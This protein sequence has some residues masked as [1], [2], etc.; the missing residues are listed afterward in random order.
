MKT[1][2]S[3]RS[4][5]SSWFC[6]LSASLPAA[7]LIALAGIAGA[8][9]VTNYFPDGQFESPNGGQGPWLN[10]FG[11]DTLTF[12][13]TGGNP[14]GCLQISDAGSF[15]GIA[16]VNPATGVTTTQPTLASMGLVAGQ[17]YTFVMDMQ[18]VSGSSIGGIKIESWTDTASIGNSGNMYPLSPTANWKTYTFIYKI[19]AGSTHLNIVPIWGPNSTVNY[20]NIGVVVPVAG[21]AS[22]A[23]TSPTNSQ[24]VYSNFT[25]AVTTAANPGAVT[26]VQFYVDNLLVGNST[27]SP[28]SF[29]AS[30]ISSGSH[31][32]KAVALDTIGNRATSSPVSISVT[33]AAIPPFGAYESFNYGNGNTIDSTVAVTG[34]GFAGNWSCGAAGTIVPGLVYPN[35]AVAN[36][37]M[38]SS[39]SYQLES[40][41]TVPSGAG[42]VWASFIFQQSGDNGGNR[43]GF[44]LEDNA[45]N[46]VM[47]AYQQN[48]AAIGNPAL[49]KV[50]GFTGNSGQL[51]PY[52]ATARNYT[53]ANFYVLKL[54]YSGGSLSSVS[55]YSN[56]TAGQGTA[57]TPDFT[58][59]SGLS[60]IGTLSVIGIVHQAAM[61]ITLDEVRLGNTFADVVGA[62]LTPTI[63][64]TVALSIAAGNQV[65]WNAFATNYYQPQSST[66]GANWNNLGNLL[67]GSAVTSVYDSAP[68]AFYQVQE[69]LPVVAEETRNGGFEQGDG[70]GG[71][72]YW[73]GGG[74]EPATQST[75]DFHSGSA[76]ESLF[77]TNST[78]AAQ[79]SDLQQNLLNMTGSGITGGSTYYF[80]FWA[81]SLGR[82]PAGGSV[83]Q[84]KISW[85]NSSAAVVGAVGFNAFT[86]GNGTWS[87]ISTGALVAPTNAVNALIEFYA[88]TGSISND[89]GGALLDDV[90]L[91]GTTPTGSINILSPTVQSG[92]VFTAT[93]QTNG[94][95]ATV[96]SGTITF[97]TNSVFQSSGIMANGTLD[98][99]PAV[100]PAS[101]T[102]TATYS[103]D[104]TYIGSANS[105]SV[106]SVGSTTITSSV[107]GGQLSLSW[108]ADHIG[109]KLQ[110]QTNALNVGLKS[111][112]H[113][114]AGSTTTNRV[115]ININPA[116]PTVFFR[117]SSP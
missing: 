58:V 80:S 78:A 10:T 54:V 90:S 8:T 114:V 117:L 61:Q 104:A 69:I 6:R 52:S 22:V 40:L 47:F 31:T 34:T 110:G 107:S 11:N 105:I 88:A 17:T 93:V 26:N 64:T 66:D 106:G 86:G 27:N 5:Q 36:N 15:G 109:W 72:A 4:F 50:T 46:G 45:G 51:T 23:I 115:F 32:L 14:D 79:T 39:G 95:T 53:D 99:T 42:T 63:P 30:G 116:N 19:L 13:P 20:D 68:V 2:L 29:I 33:N 87:Q 83:L 75:A 3:I 1:R 112:W 85:L 25:I 74:T 102:V 70:F 92:A 43:D 81:K 55:V 65:K 28:F 9:N 60:G 113:D 98:S 38:Q 108:P 73:L 76:S 96:A 100:V 41:T 49:T 111:N 84:Y 35:L 103:G 24:V 21:T 16:Y 97:K 12:S 18:I 94:V 59:S 71:A 67:Y 44:V 62:N 7:I 57:P 101:Y 82:N 77:V 48:Q 56:P 37:A 91:T 89:F